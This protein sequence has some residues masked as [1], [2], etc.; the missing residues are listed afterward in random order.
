MSVG[1]SS[2]AIKLFITKQLR[3]E[4]M[5]NRESKIVEGLKIIED[6]K[7]PDSFPR[8]CIEYPVYTSLRTALEQYEGVRKDLYLQLKNDALAYNL[9]A[10]NI[11]RDLFAAANMPT[12]NPDQVQTAI[13]RMQLGNPPGKP[14][15][16]GDA[17]NWVQLLGC[18]P[19]GEDLYLI[20][21]DKDYASKLDEKSLNTFLNQEWNTKKKSQVFFYRTLTEFFKDKYPTIQLASELKQ[22]M[23]VDAFVN[24]K[25]FQAVHMAIRKLKE[26]TDFT[27][28]QLEDMLRAS[29]ENDQIRFIKDDSDVGEYIEY[30]N[31]LYSFYERQSEVDKGDFPND[32]PSRGDIPF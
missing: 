12:Q 4:Y 27:Q 5:R 11:I 31:Y 28:E 16:Y 17:L 7:R 21:G 14:G 25:S 19:E 10:D 18:I 6:M 2:G 1:L 30:L 24:S 29:E 20:S 9:P 15:S 8:M 13:I 23:A 3:Q 26:C 22:Q 32:A